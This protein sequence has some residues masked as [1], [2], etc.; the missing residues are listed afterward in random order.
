[1]NERYLD[2]AEERLV[3]VDNHFVGDEPFDPKNRLHLDSLDVG[4][5]VELG[6]EIL[7]SASLSK[8]TLGK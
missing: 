7:T 4:E 2:L 8:E 5:L 3:R 1:M 6:M